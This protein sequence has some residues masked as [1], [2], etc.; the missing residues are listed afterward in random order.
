VLLN[1]PRADDYMLQSGVDALVATSPANVT[2]FTGFECWLASGFAEFMIEPGGSGLLAQQNFA[3]LPREGDPA[4]IVEPYFVVDTCELWVADVRPAG[5]GDYE[6][7]AD[8]VSAP[9]HLRPALDTL[10]ASSPAD[11]LDALARALQDRGLADGV[12]GIELEGR[13]PDLAAQLG[14]LLPRAR[15]RDCTNLLRLV[16]AVKTPTEIE[17]LE[18][19]AA[20]AEEA[21]HEAFASA[22]SSFS[23]LVSAYRRALGARGADFD[24]F[25]LGLRGLGVSSNATYRFDADDVLFADWG[26]RLR[27]YFSDTGTTLCFA[28]PSAEVGGRHGAIRAALDA[29]AR[30]LRPGVKGSAVQ[31]AMSEALGGHGVTGSYPFGHGFGIEHRDYPIMVADNGRHIRDDCVD[32]P[33]DLPL[34]V[35]MVVNLEVPLFTL[36]VGSMQTEQSFVVTGDGCRSLIEQKRDEVEQL[37]ST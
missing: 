32:V 33:S 12:I 30:A 27:G 9:P 4:L 5:G 20:R 24:H 16:R 25:A 10:L 21:A 18:Q 6:E 13:R 29:G 1:R 8:G 14:R 19:A 34:E 37:S 23:E 3:L 35:G 15:L 31:A 26:C 22:P 36:G 11:P 17:R 7:A 2:Y 28:P